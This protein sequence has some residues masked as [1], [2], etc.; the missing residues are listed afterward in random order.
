MGMGLQLAAVE[1]QLPAVYV[2]NQQHGVEMASPQQMSGRKSCRGKFVLPFSSF[3][4][5]KP[6]NSDIH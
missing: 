6:A 1:Q 3:S 4:V 5:G 2:V